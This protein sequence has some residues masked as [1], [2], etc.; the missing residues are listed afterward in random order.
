MIR[1]DGQRTPPR[2]LER[3]IIDIRG[4]MPDDRDGVVGI[5]NRYRKFRQAR[6]KL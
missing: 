2:D 3:A 1:D 4:E 5:A 6:A